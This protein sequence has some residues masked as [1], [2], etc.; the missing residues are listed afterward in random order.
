M[1]LKRVVRISNIDMNVDYGQQ[2]NLH[3]FLQQNYILVSNIR[4]RKSG[5]E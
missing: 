4:L 2:T 3:V 5:K 1:A